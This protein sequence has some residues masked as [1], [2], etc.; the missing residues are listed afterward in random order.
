[1]RY[2]KIALGLATAPVLFW[3]VTIFT[4]PAALYVAIRYWRAPGSLVR[5]WRPWLYLA[6]I[7]ACTEIGAWVWLITFFWGRVAR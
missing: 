4:A 1:M 6:T 2:D 7:L 5:R 3:V